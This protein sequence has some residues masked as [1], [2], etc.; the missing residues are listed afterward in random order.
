[1]VAVIIP[2]KSAT[3]PLLSSANWNKWVL[4][5]SP[6]HQDPSIS[7]FSSRP[8]L[9]SHIITEDNLDVHHV[10][11]YPTNLAQGPHLLPAPRTQRQL[12][13]LALKASLNGRVSRLFSTWLVR[14][15][16][17][18]L[19]CINPILPLARTL[20]PSLPTN[21]RFI[22]LAISDLSHLRLSRGDSYSAIELLNSEALRSWLAS[23]GDAW[24]RMLM[25]VRLY[26]STLMISRMRRST[27]SICSQSIRAANL[28]A[29]LKRRLTPK[30]LKKD[31]AT[32]V[33]EWYSYN[34][35]LYSVLWIRL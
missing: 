19:H 18:H 14:P 32:A 27:S 3:P 1:M 26:S 34:L 29:P 8:H 35:T 2:E 11:S 30:V 31:M 20:P 13:P 33:W 12:W 6:H 22:L 15:G 28:Q 23:E 16:H 9:H 17:H 7:G 21:N 4:S 5:I 10:L 24:S 25:A